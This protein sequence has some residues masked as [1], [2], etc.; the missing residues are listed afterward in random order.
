MPSSIKKILLGKPI[1]T[2]AA[3]EEKLS[4]PGGLA[5]LSSDALSSVAYATEEIL[6]IL[7]AAGTASLYLSLPIALCIVALLAVVIFS[8]RQTI[9]SYPQGGGAYLVSKANLGL[10]PGLIAAAALMI[11]YVLTVTVSVSAGTDALASAFPALRPHLVPLGALFI[12]FLSVANLRG[13]KASSEIFML[14]TYAFVISVFLMLGI[15]LWKIW[16]GLSIES[17]ASTPISETLT[18]FLILKAFSSGCTALT[19][20]E[21]I[22][23]GI[24]IF[25]SPEWK[26]AR[27]TLMIMGV[28][29]AV[30]F[31]GI[32]YLAFSFKIGPHHGQTVVSQIG[33]IVFGEGFMYYFLQGATLLILLLAANT[34]FADFPRLTY[35]LARDNFLPR[36]LVLQGDRLVYS[37]GIIALSFFS[38]LLF[39]VFQGSTQN[40]IPLYA[41][42]VFASFTLSQ[43]GMVMKWLKEKG[44]GWMT[45]FLINGLGA[46]V[47]GIVLGV[48]T[49]TK[50]AG[51]AWIVVLMIPVLV[52]F[53][54]QI[55]SHYRYVAARLSI[56]GLNPRTS[57]EIQEIRG[58]VHP[59]M[60]LVGQLHR[61]TIGA[62]DYARTISPQV[63]AVHVDIGFTNREEFTK[64]WKEMEPD[65]PLII[66]EC[67]LR[68]LVE[69]VQDFVANFEADHKGAFSTVI[70]PTFVTRNWWEN[71]LHNQTMWFI[72]NALRDRKSRIITTVN[73]YI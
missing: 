58:Q 43:S 66:L 56:K 33:R 9:K 41:V 21:A 7:V 49:V 61:G 1:P 47:T 70:I 73:Y 68:S 20:V 52:M 27:R 28:I 4:I 16:S 32:T 5:I 17:Y 8:Y 64:K 54:I 57:E 14:P 37:N 30:M 60:V 19:G 71:I 26:N 23:D 3:H 39:V 25:K 45:G 59:A 44:D 13:V 15:G 24:L 34:S 65:I 38:I 18:T 36:Q 62:L 72:E 31:L 69:T 22:S 40:L 2:S 53:F 11:D 29:L 10:Y 55:H 63:V 67:P 51:G 12:L 48:I 6:L 50:F 42:G 35:F 46:L